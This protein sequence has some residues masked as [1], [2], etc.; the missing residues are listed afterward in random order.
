VEDVVVAI[1]LHSQDGHVVFGQ[2]TFGLGHRFDLE[3]SGEITFD[4]QSVTLLNGTY[5]LTVN[6]HTLAGARVLDVR[7]Q[8]EHLDV[9]NYEENYAWGVADLAVKVDLSK[10]GWPQ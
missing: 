7:E 8:R 9:V 10:L 3:G 1:S 6:L 2:N 5:P 4:L